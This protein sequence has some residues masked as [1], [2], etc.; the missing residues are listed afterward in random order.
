M[1]LNAFYEGS[2]TFRDYGQLERYGI[3]PTV[4]LKP[5]DDTKVKLSYEYFHDE[6]T[7]DRGNPSHDARGGATRFNPATPFA[8][9][10][11]FAAFF[12]SP[13]LNVARADVQTG[14]AVVEH[15]FGNGLTVKNGT[16]L[17]RLQEI[18][19]ERLSGQRRAGGCGRSHR[20]HVQPS[21]LSAHHQSR[22][23]LQPDRFRLQDHH[24]PGPAY[25][26]VRHRVRSADR[27]RYPQYRHLYEWHQYRRRQSVRPDLFRTVTFVHHLHRDFYGRRHHRRLRTANTGSTSIPP[28]FATPSISR[29]GCS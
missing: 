27:H 29:A 17:C 16:D 22:Q 19:P 7:S 8:P 24:R 23:R 26:R 25:D 10:G 1:R 21:G 14:M 11:N 15:D 4:T 6:R 5:D 9:N 13:T 28:M 12:G 2:D 3:N 18:L 20:Q